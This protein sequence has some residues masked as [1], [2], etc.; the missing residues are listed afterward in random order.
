MQ[1]MTQVEIMLDSMTSWFRTLGITK[2]P[3]GTHHC[4]IQMNLQYLPAWGDFVILSIRNRLDTE[5]SM[6]ST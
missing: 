3:Q 4:K 1:P 2:S 6:I 5:S